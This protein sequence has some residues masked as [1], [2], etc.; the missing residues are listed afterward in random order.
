MTKRLCLIDCQK[1][2]VTTTV[3]LCCL[4]A[5]CWPSNGAYCWIFIK[6]LSAFILK[7]VAIWS[8][9]IYRRITT[10]NAVWVVVWSCPLKGPAHPV[11]CFSISSTSSAWCELYRTWL[12]IQL[13]RQ[14]EKLKAFQHV[15]FYN[16]KNRLYNLKF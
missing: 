6:S 13:N 16:F 15:C 3:S 11:S 10:Y 14:T 7:R 1:F 8:I 2:Q 5:E 9:A 12:S 4:G